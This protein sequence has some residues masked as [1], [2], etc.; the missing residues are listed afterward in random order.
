[1]T[2]I[3]V[4]KR[5]TPKDVSEFEREQL[6]FFLTRDD[7]ATVVAE[8]NPSLAWLDEF[9]KLKLIRTDT[10]L[11]SWLERNF[12]D[13]EAVRDVVANIHLFGPD[14]AEILEFRFNRQQDQLPA[15]LAKSWRLVLRHMKNIKRGLVR[16]EWFDLAP[17]V[18]RGDYSV[19]VLDRIAEVLR[20]KPRVGRHFALH[21]D[22]EEEATRPANFAAIALLSVP[23]VQHM[24]RTR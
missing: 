12:S 14:T 18:K 8:L 11:A 17:R 21:D 13:P 22:G 23:A 5:K 6:R 7:V 9:V 3:P 19:E 2:A 20:P 4:P 1:M 10:Q 16:D 15:V 24:T